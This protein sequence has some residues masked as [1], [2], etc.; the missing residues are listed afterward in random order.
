MH[1]YIHSIQKETAFA[2]HPSMK[3]KSSFILALLAVLWMLAD[4]LSA[5]DNGTRLG[6]RQSSDQ[7][8]FAHFMVRIPL[9]AIRHLANRSNRSELPVI[10]IVLLT[11]TMI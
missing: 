6:K 3:T 8:V 11:M 7:L 1:R 4:A 2:H 9:S 10:G 5:F